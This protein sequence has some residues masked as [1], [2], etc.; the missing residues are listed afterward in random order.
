MDLLEDLVDVRAVS[1]C[2][3]LVL[4]ATSGSLLGWGLGRLLGGCLEI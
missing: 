3:L 1:L 2:A 4:L